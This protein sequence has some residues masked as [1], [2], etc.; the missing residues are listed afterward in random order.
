[1]EKTAFSLLIVLA[2]FLI[3][4][5]T[6]VPV[7]DKDLLIN[8]DFYIST[9]GI[10]GSGLTFLKNG[11]FTMHYN[12]DGGFI[13]YNEGTYEIAGNDVILRPVKCRQEQGGPV[14]DCK[15]STGNIVCN[16]KKDEDSVFYSLYLKCRPENYG[17]PL[18]DMFKNQ[19]F[20]YPVKDSAV[21]AGEKK[22]IGGI[23]V[24]ATGE[25]HAITTSNVKLRAK[26]SAGAR[27]IEF[28]LYPDF[29]SPFV[30][31]NTEITVYARTETK[32]R[33]QKWENYW[34]YV[35]AGLSEPA[36]M[37]GEFIRLK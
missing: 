8:N 19:K 13:W 25:K 15:E 1:M 24:I 5:T 3:S 26:P 11:G 7:P 12:I 20:E 37:F 9:C 35:K 22:R 2:S 31:A 18:A 27:E 34:Y 33:V 4:A 28:R 6:A 36:W 23:A 30:P 32:E 17:Y 14:M 16:M 29:R 21:K 10:G